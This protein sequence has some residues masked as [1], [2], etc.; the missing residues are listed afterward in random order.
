V[1]VRLND[2][3]RLTDLADKVYKNLEPEKYVGKL[4]PSLGLIVQRD[5]GIA[6]VEVSEEF[7][8]P[9]T[10]LLFT[11]FREPVKEALRSINEALQGRGENSVVFPLTHA[12]GLG[13]THFFD[14]TLPSLS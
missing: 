2:A 6:D 8:N 10:F 11:Y 7:L 1:V 12:M 14:H 4:A 13:K 5:L 9:V 3:V